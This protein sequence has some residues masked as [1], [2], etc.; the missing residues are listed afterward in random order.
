MRPKQITL[1]GILPVRCAADGRGFPRLVAASDESGDVRA[2]R[3]RLRIMIVEDDYLIASE[4]EGALDEAGL[5]VAGV[6]SSGDEAMAMADSERVDLAVMDVRLGS[7]RDGIDAAL[8]LFAA[9]GIRC[10]FATAHANPEV[11]RRAQP[12]SPLGWVA[13]PYTMRALVVAVMRAVAELGPGRSK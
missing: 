13:K 7:G 3:R 4:I 1:P 2:H 8:E 9:H 5:D 6:A 11:R 12:A 10:V